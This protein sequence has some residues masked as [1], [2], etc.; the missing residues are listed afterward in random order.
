MGAGAAAEFASAALGGGR[1]LTQGSK[2]R[3]ALIRGSTGQDGAYLAVHAVKRRSSSFNTV[4]VDY[5][6]QKP[7]VGSLPFLMHDSAGENTSIPN[8]GY[9]TTISYNTSRLDGTPRKPLD[10]SSLTAIGTRARTSLTLAHRTHLK[11]CKQVVE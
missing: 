5:L 10:V 11:E 8:F 2:R 4:R 7:I 6:N 3:V 9:T 1:M